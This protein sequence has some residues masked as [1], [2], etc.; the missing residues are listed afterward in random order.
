[1]ESLREQA[2]RPIC[3]T[4]S[5][6]ICWPTR[7]KAGEP[8]SSQSG[9]AS[10]ARPIPAQC[11]S[12]LLGSLSRKR[13]GLRLAHVS[14]FVVK[15][16]FLALAGFATA[17]IDRG[18]VATSPIN[19]QITQQRSDDIDA[20][21]ARLNTQLN[22]SDAEERRSAVLA[23]STLET[24]AARNSLIAALGDRSERVRAAA[25]TGLGRLGDSSLATI[26][27]P[28]CWQKIKSLSY[29]NRPR[30]RLAVCAVQPVLR[31]LLPRSEIKR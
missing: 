11:H 13:E 30:M 23:L 27:P 20:E 17:S 31:R 22:S 6:S 8:A 2:S 12:P 25:I 18:E 29:A 5:L 24:P 21:I 1:M 7:S 16:L 14:G 3:L 9:T 19:P 4:T 28:R 15:L 26:M 10:D